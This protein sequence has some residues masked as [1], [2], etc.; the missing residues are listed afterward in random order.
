MDRHSSPPLADLLMD[1]M[2]SMTG[3][4]SAIYVAGPLA[5]GRRFYERSSAAGAAEEEVRRLNEGDLRNT[6]DSLR[7]RGV[8]PVIDSGIL[9]VPTWSAAEHG[10]FFLRVIGELCSLVVFVDGWEYSSGATKEFLYAQAKGIPCRDSHDNLLTPMRARSLIEAAS[11]SV[12][13]GGEPI[14]VFRRRL[15]TLDKLLE[16]Q[17]GL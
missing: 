7:R 10:D 13:G 14:D 6:V 1:A 17:R 4:A 2:R 5:T 11:I 8:A 15:Q 9:R 16:S 12:S 3:A